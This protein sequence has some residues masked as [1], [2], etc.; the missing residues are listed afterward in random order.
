ML[1]YQIALTTCVFYMVYILGD[2]PLFKFAF[3]HVYMMYFNYAR[4]GLV[5]S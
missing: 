4:G 2:P 3:C 5:L 1:N